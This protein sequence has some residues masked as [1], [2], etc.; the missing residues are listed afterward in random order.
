MRVCPEF[1]PRKGALFRGRSL[2]VCRYLIADTTRR[3]EVGLVSILF[4]KYFCWAELQSTMEWFPD[5]FLSKPPF[6]LIF[7]S[8]QFSPPQNLMILD[9][10]FL[11]MF[12]LRQTKMLFPLHSWEMDPWTG[13]IILCVIK[14]TLNLKLSNEQRI[15]SLGSGG[16]RAGGWTE[17]FLLMKLLPPAVPFTPNPARYKELDPTPFWGGFKFWL[18][19]PYSL[20]LLLPFF[21]FFSS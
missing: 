2:S 14:L 8:S 1:Q 18:R 4:I 19:N 21:F 12:L 13:E 9:M 6:S 20:A 11:V 3:D 15:S 7:C 5:W 16:C 10:I 17:F